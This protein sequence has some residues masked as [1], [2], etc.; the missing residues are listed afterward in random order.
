MARTLV[1]RVVRRM[2]NAVALKDPFQTPIFSRLYQASRNQSRLVSVQRRSLPT[3]AEFHEE[4]APLGQPV[5]FTGALEG[6]LGKEQSLALL[7]DQFGDLLLKLRVGGYQ[8]P[9][10]YAKKMEIRRITVK[11]YLSG[12]ERPAGPDLPY[13]GN[14]RL[15]AEVN[16]ALGLKPPPFYP[17]EDYKPSQLWLG[18]PGATT[19]LHKDSSDN[20][21]CQLWGRKRWLLF[22][23]RDAPHLYLKLKSPAESDDFATSAL[24]A[25]APD[26][27]QFPEFEKAVPVEAIVESGEM[28]YLPAGWCHYVQNLTTCLMIG[29]FVKL[30]P[31]VLGG[32]PRGAHANSDRLT[33]PAG[34]SATAGVETAAGF[35]KL[36]E[37]RFKGAFGRAAEKSY[38]KCMAELS[39]GQQRGT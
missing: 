20:F 21:A 14:Q 8:R 11:E 1:R 30:T 26:L 37:Q 34:C 4:I 36:I 28:L 12:L 3:L 32:E 6:T 31:A 39:R 23:V 16:E 38:P 10:T 15:G 7:S 13:A 5:I 17:A 19:P 29:Y 18:P 27:K 9:K 33:A 2:R 22:P 35:V 25:G 24:D